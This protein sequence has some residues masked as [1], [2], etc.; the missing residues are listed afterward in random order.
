VNLFAV[1]KA[2]QFKTETIISKVQASPALFQAK[3]SPILALVSA[4][5]LNGADGL[6]SFLTERR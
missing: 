4:A 6:A 3:L 1:K 5:K 2:S